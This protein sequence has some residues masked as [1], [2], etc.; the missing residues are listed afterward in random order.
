MAIVRE[1]DR[2]SAA[3]ASHRSHDAPSAARKA[4]GND[5]GP[6]ADSPNAA[7]VWNQIMLEAI[8]QTNTPPTA[9][10][11]AMACES[12]AVFNAVSATNGTPGYLA[13]LPAREGASADAAVAQA[14]HDVL[15]TLFPSQ[16]AMF[17][18][19]LAV[20]LDAIPDSESKSEG[21]ALGV[22][23]AAAM[24]ALRAGDGW[25]TSMP[26]EVGTD[27]G[28]WQPTPPAPAFP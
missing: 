18:A 7:A 1:F 4:G 9:A 11:R 8:E 28:M 22:E 23:S 20:S 25:N 12:L 10:S 15:V 27:V 14:A 26:Y 24:I 6:S 3:S 19:Q 21:I 17:D 5:D 16:T 13:D 2:G